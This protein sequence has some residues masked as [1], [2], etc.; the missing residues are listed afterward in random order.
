MRFTLRTAVGLICLLAVGCAQ[1]KPATLA[2]SE[3]TLGGDVWALVELRGQPV[4][5]G[6]DGRAISISFAAQRASGFS[7]CNRFTGAYTL[8]G[9]R[10]GFGNLAVTRMACAQG[11]QTE[12]AVLDA[13]GRVVLAVIEGDRLRMMDDDSSVLMVFQR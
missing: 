10:L 12:D 13:L 9:N 2:L 4:P 7:G 11:M 5:L 1:N 6:A 3:Q 8:E